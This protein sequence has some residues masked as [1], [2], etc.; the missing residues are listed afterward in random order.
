MA[1]RETRLSVSRDLQTIGD[2]RTYVSSTHLLPIHMVRLIRHGRAY[3]MTEQDST[4]LAEILDRTSD[5]SRDQIIW[6]IWLRDDDYYSLHSG[7]FMRCQYENK[8]TRTQERGRPFEPI[9]IR[10]YL[11]IIR[12]AI[13]NYKRYHD[14]E[15]HTGILWRPSVGYRTGEENPTIHHSA[16]AIS[17]AR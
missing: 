4:L 15:W 1:A 7:M 12:G 8:R 11:T 17:S 16:W 5:T 3:N 9:T 6:L 13:L 14:T 2:L 10:D